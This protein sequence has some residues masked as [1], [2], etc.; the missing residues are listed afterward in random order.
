MGNVVEAA[1]PLRP[2]AP[3]SG[4]LSL[5]ELLTRQAARTP[6]APAVRD[7]GRE[8][9]YRELDDM[10]AAVAGA[11]TDRGVRP[12]MTVG[13]L[14]TRSWESTVALCGVLKAG[15]VAV[16][17]DA[18]HP[19][20]RMS[21]MM[22]DSGADVVVLLTGHRSVCES[23]PV[24]WLPFAEAVEHRPTGLA[25]PA[26][27]DRTRQAQDAAYILFTSG[28]TGRP[29]AVVVPHKAVARLGLDGLPW[30]AGPGKRVLQTFGLSFDG[31][32]MEVWST[33]LNGGC[34][35]V[36]GP[37]ELLDPSALQAL[38]DR[39]QVS[40]AF[41]TMSL[42]HHAVR[43][44]PGIFAGL[45]MVLT[46][47][48]AMAVG[49]ARAV[50]DSGAPR[51]LIHGYGV[52]EAGI[53]V[54]THDLRSIARDA[55]SVPIG[56]PVAGSECHVL[57]EDGSPALPGQEGE[58]YIGGDGLA[59]GY[60]GRAEETRRAFVTMAVGG[61]A[62]VRLYHSGDRA[63]WN[64]NGTLEFLG[65]SD[66]QVKI[67]GCRIE[68][69]ALEAQ[70][71]AHPDVAEAAVLLR[72]EDDMSRT[73]SAFVT[74]AR[75]DRPVHPEQV[76]MFLAERLPA[77]SIPTPIRPVDRF[78]LTDNGKI[79]YAAL[80]ADLQAPA[81]DRP[82]QDG[83]PADD[84]P[85]RRIWAD[86]L[87]VSVH[88]DTHFFEAGGNSLLAAH[89]VNRTLTAL[90]LPP[91]RFRPLLRSLLAQPAFSAHRA[92]LAGFRES[93][94]APVPD[95]AEHA[96]FE[97]EA[98]LDL[99]LPP[100]DRPAVGSGPVRRVL[101]T[102]ATGFLGAFLLERLMR[103]PDIVVHCL[104]RAGD[105]DHARDRVRANLLRYGIEQPDPQRIEV[106]PADLS[107]AGLGLATAVRRR[108]A[109]SIDLVLHNAAHVNFIYPYSALRGPNVTAVRELI[110][111]AA[112]RRIPLHHVSSVAV[113]A[114]SGAAGVRQFTET[115]PL[116]HPEL[117]SLGY[118]ES[119]W[120]AER[121]LQH[122]ARAGLPVTVYRPY[123]ITGH[124]RTG[125]WNTDTALCALLDA[126]TRLGAAP[127]IRLP[128]DLVPV[129]SVAD[130]IVGVAT[131]YPHVA[132]VFHLTNPR[133][134]LLCD[135]VGRLRAAGHTIRE[136]PYRDWV[137]LVLEHV[138]EHPDTLVAPFAPLFATRA[139][140]ADISVKEL[141]LE[142]VFPRMDQTR[143]QQIWP[144]WKRSCPAVDT[145][146]LDH[147]VHHLHA[148]GLLAARAH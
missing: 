3:D 45:E 110:G 46:G 37:N 48:E 50:L 82:G 128:F 138:R 72:G 35:V 62:G 31:S 34:L 115:S 44:R 53:L 9:S 76:R 66:R 130:A 8:L 84:D 2:A 116:S 79:D 20:A 13:V 121:L 25:Q 77:H 112:A 145:A 71:R 100:L 40:H 1:A 104:V 4:D 7:G 106:H 14:G 59:L 15:S 27:G 105:P 114:G 135:M 36:A 70:M 22:V 142:S 124:S 89:V 134:A 97:A 64:P 147:Y 56:Q 65:R 111:L 87:G 126:I 91:D 75:P 117:I 12:G 109:D 140:H 73:L 108:L 26:P 18:H 85:V 113:L 88:P 123:E 94:S 23:L 139:N 30:C 133:P 43:F 119:K 54:T 127:A 95:P 93:G 137:Q 122:A 61:R 69:D 101:L 125:A 92:A 103:H 60:L 83:A 131:T 52:T 90:G 98:S 136:L 107:R 49:L 24:R 21:D 118:G 57:L 6:G 63:R 11:L 67:R 5:S 148:G 102:G 55:A 143:I 78:P 81:N 51:Q 99:T 144:N 58:L 33:L 41:L 120:V 16:P 39:E 74:S 10:A 32:L 42:F 129:D 17:L 96:Y 28:T 19:S 38:M 68:L 29:K 47:G 141:F 146:L 80:R 86:S 132:G